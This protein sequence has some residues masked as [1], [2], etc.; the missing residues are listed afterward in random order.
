MDFKISYKVKYLNA[1]LCEIDKLYQQLLQSKSLSDS[2]YVV[3]F[4]I[5]ELGEGCLQKDIADN[6]YV[7]KKT[8]NATIKKLEKNEIIIL[9]AGKYPNMHIYLTKKGKNYIKEKI[10]PIIDVE[11]KVLENMPESEFDNLTEIYLKYITIFKEH[12]G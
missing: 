3:L 11:N 1:M 8:I 9:K 2:E 4:A 6:S 7:N 5:L 10:F 12:V